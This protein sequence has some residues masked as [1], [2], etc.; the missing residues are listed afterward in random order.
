MFQ[1]KDSGIAISGFIDMIA[2][3]PQEMGEGE[4]LDW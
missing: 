2:V 3:S 4:S 1:V